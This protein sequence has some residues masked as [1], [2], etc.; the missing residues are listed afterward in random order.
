MDI[1]AELR[2]ICEQCPNVWEI[3]TQSNRGGSKVSMEQVAN[4]AIDFTER[5]IDEIKQLKLKLKFIT[6]YNAKLAG[7]DI[8]KIDAHELK[9]LIGESYTNADK[10]RSM[11][12][13]ELNQKLIDVWHSGY[14]HAKLKLYGNIEVSYMEW[15]KSEAK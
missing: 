2:L 12:D 14:K 1:K 3:I 8:E 9:S 6:K 11:N 13:E 5:L 10:I 7:I 4:S 15:L